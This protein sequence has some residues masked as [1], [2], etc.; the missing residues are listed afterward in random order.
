MLGS[1]PGTSGT[2]IV[3]VAQQEDIGAQRQNVPVAKM[4]PQ[5]A[6]TDI[7][8]I[9]H[10]TAQR[11]RTHHAA[12]LMAITC[13]FYWGSARPCCTASM[14]QPG[15]DA[16]HAQFD[17][18]IDTQAEKLPAVPDH[19]ENARADLLAFMALLKEIWH[20]MWSN[21]SNCERLNRE[22]RRRTDVVGICQP[23]SHHPPRRRPPAEEHDE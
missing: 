13:K 7:D 11:C 3:P 18:I 21:H 14:S 20:Q 16:L 17:R 8:A 15:A 6:I 23:G 4:D 1:D 5:W 2:P 10:V 12:N 22:I 19:L 9:L